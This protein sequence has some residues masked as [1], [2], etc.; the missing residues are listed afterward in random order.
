MSTAD[1]IQYIAY[2]S[3]WAHHQREQN[4]AESAIVFAAVDELE[5]GLREWRWLVAEGLLPGRST[6][7]KLPP[8]Y[9]REVQL[10]RLDHLRTD[11]TSS[12]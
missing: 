4:V 3:D 2:E 6:A 5:R 9:W 8:D 10:D 12:F 7:D 11:H 1:A